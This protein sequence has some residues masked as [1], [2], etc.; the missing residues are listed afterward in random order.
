MNISSKSYRFS[1][2]DDDDFTP[3]SKDPD[4]RTST[5]TT[6]NKLRN[7]LNQY[8]SNINSQVYEFLDSLKL[9]KYSQLFKDNGI[10]NLQGI[11]ELNEEVLGKLEIP[12]GH[13]LKIIKKIKQISKKRVEEIQSKKPIYDEQ[14]MLPPR[15]NEEQPEYEE[16]PYQEA[17]EEVKETVQ[18]NTS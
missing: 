4:S 13:K 10:E 3:S 18:A 8:D 5:S 6:N 7:N 1:Q 9:S 15:R 11:L 14:N 12:L 16:L 17:I 2:I